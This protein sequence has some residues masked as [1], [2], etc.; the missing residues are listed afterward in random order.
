LVE[1]SDAGAHGSDGAGEFVAE[2]RRHLRNHHGVPA[3][4][5]FHVGPAR[6]RGV[7][8]QDDLARRRRRHRKVFTAQV[9]GP[10]EDHCSHGVTY[11]FSASRR[12]I[13]STPLAR[14]SSGT[15][16]V[17][18]QPIEPSPTTTAVSPGSTR[19]RRT[20]RRQQPSGST[21]DAASSPT[22]GGTRNVACSTFGAGTRT[23]SANPPGSRF[24]VRNAAHMDSLPRR[25]K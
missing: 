4:K 13:R 22:W 2:H 21:N 20:A 7:D 14:R 25:Q 16:W 11:T 10:V 23:Y 18:R 6:Q 17:N 9:A 8:A 1:L 12:R 24:D 15:R 5:G 3:P 19:A